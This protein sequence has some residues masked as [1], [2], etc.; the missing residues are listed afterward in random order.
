[1]PESY[2]LWH[3]MVF[4]WVLT[5]DLSKINASHCLGITKLNWSD[6]EPIIN[7]QRLNILQFS[8]I[9]NFEAFNFTAA[10]FCQIYQNSVEDYNGASDSINCECDVVNYTSTMI[11]PPG[12]DL[13]NCTEDRSF[14]DACTG[15]HVLV[16]VTRMRF[17]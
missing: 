14:K 13:G 12:L 7:F 3:V 15:T 17:F 9:T 8:G 5:W 1:M 10:E 16:S 2:E 4:K 11:T 6:L